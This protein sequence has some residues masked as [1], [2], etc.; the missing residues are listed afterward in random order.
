MPQKRLTFIVIPSN[1]SQVREYRLAPQLI[2]GVSFVLLC[3]VVSFSYFTWG[4]FQKTDQEEALALLQA[5]NADLIRNVELAQREVTEFE[6]VMSQLVSDD[7]RLR[8]YHMMEPLSADIRLGG[9]GGSE[10]LPEEDLAALPEAKK[11]MMRDLSA[12]IIRLKQ[13]AR[14]QEESFAQIERQYLENEGDLRHFPTIWPV[15]QNRAW[16]SSGFG[17]R[18]DPFTGRKARHLGVDFAGRTGTPIYATGDGI[19]THAYMDRRLGNIVVIEHSV[20]EVNEQGETYVRQGKFRTEYGHLQ[21]RLVKV[22]D[23]VKRNQQIGLMGSTGRSTGPHLHYAVRYIDRQR[24][25]IKGYVDPKDFL[26]DHV[27]RDADAKMAQ[28]AGWEEE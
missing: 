14:F 22:G 11:E 7:E 3:F 26:L 1:D 20:Q 9:V 28:V 23:R 13:M 8:D 15:A 2:Y 4:Y 18:I 25:G 10:D 5:E 27:Q 24:G 21:K 16:I 17:H 6:S 19:I 12:R